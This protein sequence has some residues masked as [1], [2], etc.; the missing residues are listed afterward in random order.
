MLDSMIIT[1]NSAI[2]TSLNRVW[3]DRGIVLT[4]LVE[5]HIEQA[6]LTDLYRKRRLG[7]IYSGLTILFVYTFGCHLIRLNQV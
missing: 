6:F 7:A 2:L 1:V 3:T 5:L 4:Y